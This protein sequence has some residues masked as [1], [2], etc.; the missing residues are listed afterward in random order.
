METNL[1]FTPVTS[2]N[3]AAFEALFSSPGAP[4]F[5]WCMVWRRT[6]EESHRHKPADR[7]Q[8]MMQRIAAAGAPIG[9][10]AYDNG[11]PA[12]WVSIAPRDTYRN[13]GGPPAKPDENIWSIACFYVPR[14]RRGRGTVRELI[15]G[16]IAH[17]KNN[18]A[19][20]VEAYP[21]PPDAP[22]YRFMGFIPLF[23]AA[24][25]ADHGMA[26]ARRHVMRL[27]V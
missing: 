19:T 11:E 10:I 24:G 21:V 23:A 20:I 22:S 7:K 17:A 6:T 8:Q 5:C 13:L 1:T 15:A 26:G 16:A 14:K 27:E 4:H 12:G 18:G 3:V 9:L 2:E 25:F